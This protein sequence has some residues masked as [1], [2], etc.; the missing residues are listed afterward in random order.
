MSKKT[1]FVA[2]PFGVEFDDLWEFGILEPVKSLGYECIRADQMVEPGFVMNQVFELI[3][4]ADIVI[5]EMTGQNSNVFYEIGY[6]HALGK[7][8]ILLAKSQDDLQA[9]N[10]QG[11]RH[12]LHNGTIKQV[13]QK[14]NDVLPNLIV[15]TEVWPKVPRGNVIY[16]WP[17]ARFEPPDLR[18]ILQ[19]QDKNSPIDENG[20]QSLVA[21]DHIG[22]S[23]L[24]ANT[25]K[26]WNRHPGYSIMR[27]TDRI[28]T[29]DLGDLVVLLL[30]GRTTGNLHI[31]LIG[32]GGWVDDNRQKWA[33]SWKGVSSRLEISPSW[34]TW[35]LQATVNPTYSSYNP[36]QR[37]T[38]VYLMNS[39][40][41][42]MAY[43]K[44][45]QLVHVPKNSL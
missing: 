20:G 16:E 34:S 13:R 23:I 10:T 5:G 12:F 14:L 44:R 1:V 19:P 42:A 17:S 15:Q 25:E 32:D 40:G 31:S 6:A 24:V 35:M 8:T 28:N 36:S 3:A 4:G 30:S 39:V 41:T 26:Y 43:Y 45:I 38:T 29:F 22:N 21:I 9:F 27:L 7:P 2:M 37:G 33:E 11:F 18:W